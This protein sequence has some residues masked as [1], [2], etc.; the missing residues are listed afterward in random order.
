MPFLYFLGLIIALYAVIHSADLSIRFAGRLATS[1]H[2]SKFVVGFLLVAIISILPE[3]FIAVSSA[4]QGTPAFGL[5]TLFGSNVADLS[6]VFALV[7]II[8][9][10][11]L[12]VQSQVIKNSLLHVGMMIIPIAFGFDGYYSRLEGLALI[13]LGLLFYLYVIRT[14]PSKNAPAEPKTPLRVTDLVGILLSMFALLIASHFTVRFGVLFAESLY[15]SPIIVGMFLVGLG[16]TLPELFFALR[17]AKRKQ[18]GLALG[19]I[20][21]TVISDATIV[22]G[23]IAVIAPFSFNYRIARITG[24]AMILAMI[25]LLHCMRTGRVLT[26]KEAVLLLAFYSTFVI[27]ELVI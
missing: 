14:N 3:T 5:G 2:L 24:V 21:G 25:L 13:I 7:I 15:V 20:L 19:D 17:A 12:R 26:K 6:L 23:V 4:F 11:D 8:S 10:R 1:F 22:V 27:A 9:G 18:D 16:T